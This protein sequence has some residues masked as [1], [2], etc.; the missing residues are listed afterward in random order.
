MEVSK[1][2]GSLTPSLPMSQG[3]TWAALISFLCKSSAFSSCTGSSTFCEEVPTP[4]ASL[5]S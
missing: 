1:V 3:L 4:S 2:P 5:I